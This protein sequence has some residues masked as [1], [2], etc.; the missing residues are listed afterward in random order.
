MEKLIFCNLDLLKNKPDENDYEEYDF[1]DFDFEQFTNKRNIFMHKFKELSEESDNK[2]YFY[3]RKTDL[4]KDYADAF[5]SHGYT[6][7]LFKDRKKIETF[8]KSYKNKS[9]RTRAKKP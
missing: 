3:S 9:K 8:V 6:N 4:L 5:H 2:I 1:S 7:F